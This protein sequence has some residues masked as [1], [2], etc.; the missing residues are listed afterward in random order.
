FHSCAT[1]SYA[2]TPLN[3][4]GFQRPASGSAYMG[5][6][7]YMPQTPDDREIIEAPLLYPLVKNQR[8]FLKMSVST[9]DG[10]QNNFYGGDNK[11][12]LRLSTISHSTS[13]PPISSF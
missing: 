7:S 13:P 12:G 8:Y 9:A 10:Y 1:Y 4:I 11:V 5:L 2:S 6:I 3:M